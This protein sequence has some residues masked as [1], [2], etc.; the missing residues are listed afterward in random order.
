MAITAIRLL[1]MAAAVGADF[2]RYACLTAL[3]SV[4]KHENQIFSELCPDFSPKNVPVATRRALVA[5]ALNFATVSPKLLSSCLF[6][7]LV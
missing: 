5:G 3:D 7:K 1:M 2:E 6:Y 4:S